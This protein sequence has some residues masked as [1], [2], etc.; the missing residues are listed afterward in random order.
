VSYQA[1]QKKRIL[2]VD[3]SRTM[4]R[5]VASSLA[6]LGQCRFEEAANGLEAIERLVL[7][8]ADLMI[9]DLNMP[10]IHGIEV[11]KFVRARP[12]YQSM[13]IIV[14]TTKGEESIQREALEAGANL[15]LTKPF[16]ANELETN[17]RK[18][19]AN[20]NRATSG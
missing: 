9:L 13:S 17:V 7:G 10:E 16:S 3:D 18:M 15:Y 2:I 19:L 14:L 8:P 5:M 11:L 4:R 12:I 6:S 1:E 20:H